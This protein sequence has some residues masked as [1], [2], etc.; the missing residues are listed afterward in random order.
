MGNYKNGS[1]IDHVGVVWY[2]E[3]ENA[4]LKAHIDEHGK[5]IRT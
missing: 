5:S 3:C 1:D 4:D 2:E